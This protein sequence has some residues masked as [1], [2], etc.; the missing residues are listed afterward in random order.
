MSS[1]LVSSGEHSGGRLLAGIM[2]HLNDA[3]YICRGMGGPELESLGLEQLVD[4]RHISAT[5]FTE[6]AHAFLPTVQAYRTLSRALRTTHGVLLSDF[7]EVN[8]RLVTEAYKHKIPSVYVAPPQ[9]WAWRP[10]R[11]A[12]LRKADL[13]GCLFPF[14]T[15]WFHERGVNA[16][17]MGHPLADSEPPKPR[18]SGAICLMP[19]SRG[20]TVSQILPSMIALVNELQRRRPEVQFLCARAPDVP[21]AQLI[22]QFR[23]CQ[24]DVVILDD[25]EHALARSQVVIAH[26]GTATLHAALRGCSVLS[27]CDPSFLTKWVARRFLNLDSVVLPNILIGRNAFPEYIVSESNVDEWVERVC[28][29]LD[30]P[31]RFDSCFH[32]IWAACYNP[33]GVKELTSELDRLFS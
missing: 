22:E 25:V 30:E 8:L 24:S 5:G 26:P 28:A 11:V 19:G 21:R 29:M 10:W 16:C 33:E 32:A 12:R 14:T 31:T 2:T 4:P 15:Q 17:W 13:V 6:A 1:I 9:A 18:T 3:G 20:R 23:T 27:L 7:P